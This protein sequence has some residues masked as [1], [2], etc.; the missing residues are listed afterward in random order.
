MRTSHNKGAEIDNLY[1]SK[2][3]LGYFHWRR[4]GKYYRAIM[5]LAILGAFALVAYNLGQITIAILTSGTYHTPPLLKTAVSFAVL[6]SLI[7]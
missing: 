5:I 7:V 3:P 6:S 2:L 4:Y 1:R